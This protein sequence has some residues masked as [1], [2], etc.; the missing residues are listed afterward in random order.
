[1]KSFDLVMGNPPYQENTESDNRNNPFIPT[2]DIGVKIIDKVKE[3]VRENWKVIHPSPNKP[4]FFVGPAYRSFGV[5][6]IEPIHV[7]S[8]E[9]CNGRV[10]LIECISKED[11][12]K[13]L[14]FYK[15]YFES[16]LMRYV[17]LITR[18]SYALNSPQL[19]YIPKIS[20]NRTWTDQELYAHFGL[21]DEEIE[22]IDSNID[23]QR[24]RKHAEETER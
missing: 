3:F 11:A 21:T 8:N 13:A 2:D 9:K 1:M 19:S 10:A 17:L 5:F 15:T 22:Y 24:G 4:A 6:T 14:P 20:M 23:T 16:K 7:F 12:E 18:T